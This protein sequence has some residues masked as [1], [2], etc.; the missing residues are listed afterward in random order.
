MIEA[1][2][3]R[4]LQEASVYNEYTI[5]KMYLKQEYC[6]SCAI[7]AHVVRCRP[8]D[9]RRLRD[10]PTKLRLGQKKPNVGKPQRGLKRSQRPIVKPVPL[11]TEK[12]DE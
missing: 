9:L 11:N 10:P 12:R 3:E 8:A 7:H 2:A 4:D 1:A 6:V 5:P